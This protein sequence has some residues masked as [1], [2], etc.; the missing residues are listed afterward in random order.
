MGRITLTRV[1]LHQH[2]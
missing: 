2:G 1:D